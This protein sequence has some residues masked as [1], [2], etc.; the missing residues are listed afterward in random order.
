MKIQHIYI[1]FVNL[2]YA[3]NASACV[4]IRINLFRWPHDFVTKSWSHSYAN[5]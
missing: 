5:S 3:V 1:T 4:V 2:P